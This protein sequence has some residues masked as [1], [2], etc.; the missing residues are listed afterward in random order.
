MDSDRFVDDSGGKPNS[1]KQRF[2]IWLHNW[3][4]WAFWAA[5][6]AKA[7]NGKLSCAMLVGVGVATGVRADVPADIDP[8][9][10]DATRQAIPAEARKRR[11]VF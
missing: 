6:G 8:Q 3:P 7:S 10:E 2:T 1:R 4:S 11:L 9:P 5:E